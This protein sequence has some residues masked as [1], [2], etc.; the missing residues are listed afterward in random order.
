M[1]QSKFQDP[2]A[3]HRIDMVMLAIVVLLTLS[4]LSAFSAASSALITTSSLY[5][6]VT[7]CGS[8]ARTPLLSKLYDCIYSDLRVSH[9]AF[10]RG[11]YLRTDRN[12]SL[13][14]H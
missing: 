7:S 8:I 4:S 1:Q 12:P 11:S 13:D 6:S 14:E 2:Q 3:D 10:R 9:I 5:C